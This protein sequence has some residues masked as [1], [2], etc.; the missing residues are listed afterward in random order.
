MYLGYAYELIQLRVGDALPVRLARKDI[1]HWPMGRLIR[2]FSKFND[3]TGLIEGMLK[4]ASLRN[5]VV[6]RG[7][8]LTVEETE[9]N[10]HMERQAERAQ[11]IADGANGCFHALFA[12]I[13]KLAERLTAL[14]GRESPAQNEDRPASPET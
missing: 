8:L 12:E 10:Q 14:R 11:R 5:E 1:E 3:N 7:L 9:D 13:G 6:H 2:E 4:L